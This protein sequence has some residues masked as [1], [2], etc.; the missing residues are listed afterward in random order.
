MG[1]LRVWWSAAVDYDWVVS[2]H[3]THPVLRT[4]PYLIATTFALFA[5][6]AALNLASSR[7]EVAPYARWV[8]ACVVVLSLM[9]GV[10]WLQGKLPTRTQSRW[11]V[12]VGDSEIAAMLFSLPQTPIAIALGML[13]APAGNYTNV[14][15][16]PRAFVV[17]H[18]LSLG[19]V[20]V[21]FFRVIV[22]EPEETLTALTALIAVI[23]VLFA[24]SPLN[25]FFFDSLRQDAARSYFDHLT[26]LRNRRGLFAAVNVLLQGPKAGESP[27]FRSVSAIS[28]DLDS[29][30]AV[31][32]RF[33]HA[34]GDE[35]LR[36]TAARIRRLC[37]D[38]AIGARLGGEEFVVVL[39][40]E[41]DRAGQLACSLLSAIFNA[42]DRAP[43]S[44][45]IGVASAPIQDFESGVD[46]PRTVRALID[47]ADD[48]MYEAKRRG[49]NRIVVGRVRD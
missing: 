7:G 31:N 3:R 16:G 37:G 47:V 11:F 9:N 22:S 1:A 28:I 32:D 26:G 6:I 45:S 20:V 17:H 33:G 44:A 49:G 34:T 42:D 19:V 39:V 18:L 15:H 24:A 43:V 35:V 36:D 12:A 4:A 27:N 30:K 8:L 13:F 5:F 14:F 10:W 46:M 40:S 41:P 21:L 29:F 48:A 38:E 2:Y 23:M 25:H